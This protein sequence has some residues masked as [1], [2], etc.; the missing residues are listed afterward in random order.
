[1]EIQFKNYH[2]YR[3]NTDNAINTFNSSFYKARDLTLSRNVGL[4]VIDFNKIC[5]REDKSNILK[6]CLNEVRAMID[7]GDMTPYVPCIFDDY[8]DEGNNVFYIAM[9]II[10]GDSLDKKMNVTPDQFLQWIINL[11]DILV[12]MDKRHLHHKDIKPD[13]III[14]NRNQLYLIDFNISIIPPNLYTGTQHYK[15]PEMKRHITT[16][17][18][19]IDMFS[20]GVILYKFFTKILPTEGE[21]YIVPRINNAE[22]WDDFLEPNELNKEILPSINDVIVKC[23]KYHPKDRYYNYNELKRA[24]INAKKEYNNARKANRRVR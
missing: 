18:S 19:K 12:L 5:K 9:Q 23:M 1:M 24:L 17:T 22:Q 21:Y 7:I 8:Y 16:D 2:K 14:D 20:I 4:K 15:A 6:L 13:N 10:N 11:C 3:V